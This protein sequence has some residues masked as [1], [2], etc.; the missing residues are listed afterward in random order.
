MSQHL[1]LEVTIVGDFTTAIKEAHDLSKFRNQNIELK[2]NDS[3]WFTIRPQSDLSDI[4]T[5]ADNQIKINELKKL[6]NK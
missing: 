4:F 2:I 5:M 1:R 6:C 3:S